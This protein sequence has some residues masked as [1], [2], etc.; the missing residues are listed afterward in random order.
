MKCNCCGTVFQDQ[1]K[2]GDF[3]NP[4]LHKFTI[5]FAY[6]SPHDG[7]QLT[8]WKCDNCLEKEIENF[9]CLPEIK[10]YEFY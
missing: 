6:G 4:M 1:A 8:F 3:Y 7:T 9:K 5:S 2:E 10:S